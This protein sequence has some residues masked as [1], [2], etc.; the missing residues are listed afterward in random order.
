MSESIS[1][2]PPSPTLFNKVKTHLYT[3]LHC[4]YMNKFINRYDGWLEVHYVSD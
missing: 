3:Q 2:H 4:T 1:K